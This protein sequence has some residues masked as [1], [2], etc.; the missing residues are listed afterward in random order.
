MNI[1]IDNIENYLHLFQDKNRSFG[2]PTWAEP[3]YA[4]MIRAYQ[5]DEELDVEVG[6]YTRQMILEQYKEGKSYTPIECVSSRQGLEAISSHLTGIMMHNFSRLGKTDQRDLKDYLQYLFIELMNNIADHAY[7]SVGGYTMA[8]YFK[9]KQKI[10]FVAV[11]R[12][13]GFLENM[14]LNFRG[15]ANEEEAIMMALEKGITSTRQKM[16]QHEKNAG[17]GLYAMFEILKLTGGKFVII[18]NDTLVRYR[19]GNFTTVKLSHPWKGVIVAFDFFEAKI[20]YD[21]DYFRREYL[22]GS[23]NK[24]DDEDYF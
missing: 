19:N 12:G 4:A 16:Y 21:M 3:I 18:S 10:Q 2:K 15:V 11:D 14:L 23:L 7:S 20:N 9:D 8:Q 17:F 13:V 22:W 5:N 1:T 6:G 24:E